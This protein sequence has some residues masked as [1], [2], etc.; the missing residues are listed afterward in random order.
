[1]PAEV[2]L[3]PQA[4]DAT[5]GGAPITTQ[6]QSMDKAGENN[7][8][9]SV[10]PGFGVAAPATARGTRPAVFRGILINALEIQIKKGYHRFTVWSEVQAGLCVFRE[11]WVLPHSPLLFLRK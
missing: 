11:R 3:W 7:R 6:P 8:H 1:M 4:D 9:K 5:A 10:T 2:A